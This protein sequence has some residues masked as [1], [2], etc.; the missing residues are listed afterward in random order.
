MPKVPNSVQAKE[1][2]KF[3]MQSNYDKM[4]QNM[5]AKANLEQV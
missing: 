4:M 5:K 2:S 3:E 1:S